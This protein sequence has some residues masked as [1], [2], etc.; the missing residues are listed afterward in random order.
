MDGLCNLALPPPT[1]FAEHLRSTIHQWLQHTPRLSLSFAA[2][3]SESTD[4]TE[5]PDAAAAKA[6]S[7][8]S[9]EPL[10]GQKILVVE[11]NAMNQVVVSTFLKKAGYLY[12]FVLFQHRITYFDVVKIYFRIRV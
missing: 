6:A 1:P 4:S 7:V 2:S 9:C 8:K 11:D 10:S 3:A 5:N 12:D